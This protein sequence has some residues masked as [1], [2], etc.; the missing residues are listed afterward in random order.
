MDRW[1]RI[2]IVTP[3]YNQGKYIA[4][5]IESVLAQD[6]PNLEHIVVDGGSTD[7]TLEILKRYPHLIVISEPDQGQS[8]AI[9]KGFRL[10]TGEIWGYLCSDDTLLPGAL[11]RVA[12]EIDPTRGRHV[13]MGRCRMTDEQGRYTGIEHPSHFE[14][15]RRVLE[16]WKGHMIPQPAVF[17]TPEVWQRCGGM[18]VGLKYHMDYD[19]FCRMSRYYCFHSIDQVLATYR[20]QPE[21][22]TKAWTEADR[23]EDSIRLSR[24]YWGSPLSP[25]YW[26]LAFSLAVY[27]FNRVGRARRLHE[28]AQGARRQRQVLL[29]LVYDLVA[30]LLAPEV[31]FYVGVYPALRRRAK[32]ILRR[33]LE[34]LADMRGM[35]PQTAVYLERTDVWG[36]G[37]VGPRL[38]TSR[39]VGPGAQRI[40]IRGDVDLRYI[41]Q[42]FVLTVL[43]DGQVVGQR[44][45]K[46][47]GRFELDLTLPEPLPA[48]AHTVEIRSSAWWVPH[49]I[50]RSGDHRPLAW[51]AVP[52]DAVTL[53]S[54][55]AALIYADHSGK[56]ISAPALLFSEGWHGLEASSLDWWRWTDGA[57]RMLVLV[58]QD[59]DA[60]IRGEVYSI[61]G[62]NAMDIIANGQKVA[63]VEVKNDGFHPLDPIRLWLRKGENT[64]E[65]ISHHPPV[66]TPTDSR[67]LAVAVKNMIVE[68]IDIE[69]GETESFC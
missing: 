39:Q 27:R 2:T 38:V 1:P 45:I 37:W 59:T 46:Q 7:D 43:I 8:D 34:R 28:R 61:A 23:L 47:G 42:P 64:V 54:K 32:G 16:V 4:E 58:E 12:Q 30:A 55:D 21:S 5:T 63:T 48:G 10:A 3:S 14:S 41:R 15:H 50:A 52:Q 57:G 66:T 25:M 17:W 20:L 62:P 44:H 26:R 40:I 53:C 69:E 24:R 51:R 31:A 19:L 56:S 67:P 36:D 11:H 65:F 49:R 22:K 35:Y 13:V 60:L 29:A 33:V 68:I 18:D 6:Y 9:N